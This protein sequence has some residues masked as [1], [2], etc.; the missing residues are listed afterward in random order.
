MKLHSLFFII[1]VSLLT[2]T[3]CSTCY[4]VTVNQNAVKEDWVNKVNAITPSAWTRNADP[5]FLTG[6][7]NHLEQ[8]LEK[9]RQPIGTSIMSVRAGSFDNIIVNG[10]FEVQIVG[11]QDCDS[12]YVLGPN[13]AIRQ[14]SVQSSHHTLRILQVKNPSANL[15]TVIVRIGV[16]N[17]R[18]ITNLGK[19]NIYGRNIYSDCLTI[20]ECDCGSVILSGQMNLTKVKQLGSG[21]ITVIGAITP[22]LSIE[23]KSNG[24]VNVCGRVGI[25]Q[26]VNIGNGCVNV[27]G[28]DSDSLT[29][30]A[31]GNGVTSVKGYVN[32][33][34]VTACDRSCVF[35]FCVNSDALYVSQSDCSRVGLAGYVKNMNIDMIDSSRFEGQYL[36]GGVIYVKTRGTAH[37][38]VAPDRKIFAAA[39]NQSSIYMFGSPD[40][41]SRYP[42]GGGVILPV[43]NDSKAPYA[44][45]A[46]SCP[47]PPTLRPQPIYKQ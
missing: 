5:W 43:W 29:I 45:P 6:D 27:V 38:N 47:V 4:Q 15:K 41:V 36:K 13:D 23:V 35:V 31:R 7:P 3:A 17:L 33:K 8:Y 14:V 19:G 2:L 16:R 18:N 46:I 9:T 40:I 11:G 12:V 24:S 39:M 21:T 34:K 25:Q 28:A 42:N 20:T 10:P 26:I 30:L 44:M 37:A 1:L 32:L 22:C